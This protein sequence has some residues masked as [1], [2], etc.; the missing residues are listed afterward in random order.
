MNSSIDAGKTPGNSRRRLGPI[1]KEVISSLNARN[2][3]NA[4]SQQ[5]PNGAFDSSEHA[6]GLQNSQ[7]PQKV[8]SKAGTLMN[9]MDNQNGNPPTMGGEGASPGGAGAYANSYNSKTMGNPMA[10]KNQQYQ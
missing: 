7:T 2:N 9:I 5:T 10:R 4:S 8:P 3:L 6:Y 1:G